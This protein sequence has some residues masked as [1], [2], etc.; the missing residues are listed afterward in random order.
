MP[1]FKLEKPVTEA[2]TELL[3]KNPFVE[4]EALLATIDS[5]SNDEIQ[6]FEQE[7]L[8]PILNYLINKSY[9]EVH[10]ILN[11]IF[12]HKEDGSF[13]IA[14][15]PEEAASESQVGSIQGVDPEIVAS[16]EE[17]SLDV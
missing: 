7:E 3:R 10:H 15:E 5:K 2:I 16:P 13:S 17:T 14:P 11:R 1:K 4:V 9:N 6:L 12:S 8:V